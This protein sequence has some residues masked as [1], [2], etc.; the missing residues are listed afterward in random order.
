LLRL[1]NLLRREE[2]SKHLRQHL[3]CAA[4]RLLRAAHCKSVLDLRLVVFNL[5][6]VNLRHHHCVVH[7]LGRM[8]RRTRGGPQLRNRVPWIRPSHRR[9][10]LPLDP[11]RTTFTTTVVG[12]LLT[13]TLQR[14][15][16]PAQRILLRLRHVDE[17]LERREIGRAHV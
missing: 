15:E 2:L 9:Y 10:L 12:A 7:L 4:K 1:C 17:A 13:S 16:P 11:L 8:C 14:E 5:Q 6:R 3:L